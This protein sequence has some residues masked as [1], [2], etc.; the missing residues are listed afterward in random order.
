MKY[1]SI[2]KLELLLS[3]TPELLQF[4]SRAINHPRQS[5]VLFPFK[6]FKQN[7]KLPG[8]LHRDTLFNGIKLF[9]RLP[10]LKVRYSDRNDHTHNTEN[11]TYYNKRL[12]K[13][14]R[15]IAMNFLE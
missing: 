15:V 2:R 6:I 13:S 4:I 12:I 9:S 11:Y 7:Q 14:A 5:N 10:S 3:L 1:S 8:D